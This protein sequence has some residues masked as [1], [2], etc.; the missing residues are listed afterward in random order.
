MY[1]QI[2]QNTRRTWILMTLAVALV[3][4]LGFV[5][6]RYFGIDTQTALFGTGLFCFMYGLV[7]YYAAD[8]VALAVGGAHPIAKRDAPELYTLVENLCIAG[9]LPLPKIYIIQDPSPNAFATGR[10][11]RHASLAFTTGILALLEKAELEGVVAHELSHVKNYDIRVMT[12]VV[13]LVGAVALLADIFLRGQF[14]HRRDREEGGNVFVVLGIVLA[15]LAPIS[16]QLIRF[17]VSRQREYLADASGAMLT[18]YPEGLA[19]ALEKIHSAAAEQPLQAAN[20]ATAHMYIADPFAAVG[21]LFSTH[22]PVEERIARLRG[23]Q[24]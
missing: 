13:V 19:R 10:D 3:F 9:G 23:K 17:S 8:K 6:A 21:K 20:R 5:V 14:F 11:P 18:R 12:V 4:G 2:A 7:S 16:V 15:I 22:P 1:S 24:S